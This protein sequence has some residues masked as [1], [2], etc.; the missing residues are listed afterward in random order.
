MGGEALTPGPSSPG[1]KW[2]P[3]APLNMEGHEVSV[4]LGTRWAGREKE[5]L[6]GF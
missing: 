6:F 5:R 4:S 3:L 2:E 1:I